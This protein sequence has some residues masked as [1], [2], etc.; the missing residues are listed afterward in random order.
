MLRIYKGALFTIVGMSAWASV[1]AIVNQATEI[2][3][4]SFVVMSVTIGFL[5][6]IEAVTDSKSA[7]AP[8]PKE[9]HRISK[10]VA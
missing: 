9:V 5:A 2:A 6:L 7:T 1:G 4:G 10:H 3:I 8:E